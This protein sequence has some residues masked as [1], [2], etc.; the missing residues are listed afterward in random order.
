MNEVEAK[1][2]LKNHL[3]F[4]ILDIE[5]L[6][7]FKS[8]LLDFNSNYNLIS[9]NTLSFIWTRHVLD[10]AQL[11]SL[12]NTKSNAS[13]IDLG[14]GAG[15]PG[16][17]ISIFNKNPEFHV[18]LYEKSPVKR[19]FLNIIKEKLKI[20]VDIRE[21]VY[22]E[23]IIN[24]DIIVARAFKKLKEIIRIS[25]ETVKKP[26]KIIILKGKNAQEEIN[27]ISLEQNYSYKLVKSITNI[28]SKIII[29]NAK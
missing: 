16:L 28:D 5:R 17:I 20:N 21:N 9:D 15:F 22:Q 27:N 13:L 14:S 24:A 3:N 23:K 19:K 2:Y 7:T 11:L 10:S 8:Q 25:R 12:I 29:V 18:K 26:H 6:E 4:T 1:D